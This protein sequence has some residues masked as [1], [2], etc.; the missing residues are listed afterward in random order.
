MRKNKQIDF[1]KGLLLALCGSRRNKFI[2]SKFLHYLSPTLRDSSFMYLENYPVMLSQYVQYVHHSEGTLPD[3]C[4]HDVPVERD[5]LLQVRRGYRH[6]VQLAQGPH[7][8][9]VGH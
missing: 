2:V 1:E 9:A 8:V 3:F 4:S 7:G 5:G 6:V